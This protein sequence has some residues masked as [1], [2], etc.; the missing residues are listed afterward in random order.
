MAYPLASTLENNL[1]GNIHYWQLLP[2]FIH[3]HIV[4]PNPDLSV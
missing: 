2:M 3:I 1:I 4:N